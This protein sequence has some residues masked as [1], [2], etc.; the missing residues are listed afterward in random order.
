MDDE[1]KDSLT[2]LKKYYLAIEVD[3]TMTKEEK[4][5]FMVEWW[6][7]AHGII[8]DASLTKADIQQAV[9]RA[10]LYLR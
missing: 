8:V 1:I 2:K 3:P 6:T 10:N 5:P 9:T 7:K 4:L